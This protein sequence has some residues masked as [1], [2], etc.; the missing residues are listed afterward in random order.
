MT[1]LLA[2]VAAFVTFIY[3]VVSKAA[4]SISFLNAH[5]REHFD[6][7]YLAGVQDVRAG[8][9]CSKCTD[10]QALARSYLEKWQTFSSSE[11]EYI[12]RVLK[13]YLGDD[14]KS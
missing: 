12:D 2:I 1:I 4:K 3:V 9:V 10:L 14:K 6:R 8:V 11:E 5:A 7:G 13:D